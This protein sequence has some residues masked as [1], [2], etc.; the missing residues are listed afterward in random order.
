M[1]YLSRAPEAL[2]P[3]SRRAWEHQ[4]GRALLALALR[5][6]GLA[7][8]GE[9]EENLCFGPRGKPY[10]KGNPVYFNISHGGG[11]AAC[12]VENCPVGLDLEALRQFRPA[13][14]KRA[15]TPAERQ[16]AQASPDP[17]GA[18]T[19]LWTCK[20]S[21]MKLSGQGMAELGET[22]LESLGRH[23]ACPRAGVWLESRN[24]SGCWLTEACAAPFTLE[25][26][27]A[28]LQA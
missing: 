7:L 11:L 23:P 22:V 16:L 5:E 6:R 19:Q 20:E 25:L 21:L 2:P 4:T 9:L 27:W 14:A 28:D 15:F 3:T 13:L 12:A 17:D 18:L 1:V 24:L 26:R 8:P 10:L